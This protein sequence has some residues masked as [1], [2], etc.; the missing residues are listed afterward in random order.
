MRVV[1]TARFGAGLLGLILTSAVWAQSTAALEGTV[2][3]SSGA[4]VPAAKI[5]VRN[6]ATG[7]ERAALS[8]SAGVYLAPS[9]PVGTYSVSVTAPGMQKVVANNILLEIGRTVQQSFTLRAASSSETV[10]VAAAAPLVTSETVDVGAVIDQKTVQDI[11]L[12]GR[13][14]LDMGFLVP[15]SVT[16]PQNAGL[17]A[18]L[19]GQGFFGFNS[20][21]SRDDTINFMMNGIN[22]NDPSNNQITFQP[23]IAT[24]QEFKV[25]NMTFSAEYGR[26]SG[27]IVNIATR[28]GT[29]LW[30]GELYEYLRNNAM[31]ARNFGNPKGLQA[32][33]PFHRNQFGG[34]GGGPIKKDKTFFYLSYEG[35]RHV[36]GI[37]LSSTV[38]TDAQRAQ[39]A[40]TGDAVVRKLLTLI[41]TA[42]SP[43]GVFISSAT[44]PVSLDQGTVNFSHSFSDSSRLNVYYAYQSDL[45]NEP[46]STLNNTLPGYGDT[47][48]GHRQLL[49]VNHT[50]VLS[51][52][53]VNEARLGFNRIHITFIPI[54]NLSSTDYGI[55]NGTS[56]MPQINIA[57]GTLEFGG[58]SGEPNGRGDYTAVL[59][60]SLNWVRGKHSIK[61]GGEYRRINN[62]NFTYSPGSFTF[63]SITAFINDQATGF[64]AN[65]S[66]QA[67]RIYGNA[68]GFFVQDSYRVLPNFMV[69]AG[70]RY[71]WNST[72]TEG[73][74]R[75][76]V[77]DPTTR[78]LV[79]STQPFNQS[80]SFEPRLGF[81]WDVFGHGKAVI[82]AA[83]ALQTDQ[84]KTSLV[85][86]LASNPPNAFPV[87]F[88]PTPAT[89][90]VTFSN[91]FALA[92]GSVSPT[93]IA[94]NYKDAYVQ[95]WNFNIQQ[96]LSSSLSVMAG[97]FAN[98][99]TDLNIG[100][101]Y[102]Q[103]IG[104]ARPY[105]ALSANSPI[106]PGRPLANITVYE[107]GGNSTYNALWLT[108]T[109]RMAKGLQFN[110][111][112]TWSK[113]ID[114][115]S[116]N[117]QGVAVQ[118]SYNL[119]GDR[120]LSDYDA[121][122]RLVL[123]GLYNL[124]FHGN[125]LVEGWEL[126]TILTLQ[127]GNPVTF[128]TSNRSLTGSGNIR[129]SATGPVQV[130]YSPAPNGNATYVAYVQNPT[131]FYDQGNA[132]GNVGRNVVIGPGFSNLD[133]AI[134]KN[135]K[136]REHLTWQ[137]RGDAFDI[138]NHAN[139][140]QPGGT[141]GTS[142]FGQITNTRW[143]TGDSGSSRQLQVAMKLTF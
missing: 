89:P 66:N 98:K 88:S 45:R 20:A 35:L 134:I 111:S 31:D 110:T 34:D 49:T 122:H 46:P 81:S 22:L 69:V 100:R 23:T 77:F 106:F 4:V 9:L 8:D 13:H 90:F 102:N 38:L 87:S 36:Q 107:S 42:N 15:G 79:P 12:N 68:L 125:R 19:R 136:L 80:L 131:V 85:A 94:R 7:E 67:S 16:P 113:S 83:Y 133:F 141:V 55:N 2:T 97:Y 127:S 1:F 140:G 99:G 129:A 44:A 121:R 82:R 29:N 30:H 64:A 33:S 96:Q 132:F 70:L 37:P 48:T 72:P 114:Y 78:S 54:A 73:A 27:A 104:G 126:A 91:A 124:P 84:P 17:A 108:A 43:G 109:K 60:D 76:V 14:F 50:E 57:G 137:V 115:N 39:A 138:L 135:V 116:R 6:L 10:E 26:N 3:D 40:A 53:L 65:P 128:F 25:D 18:P 95:S 41:P 47:R 71:D 75:F 118:D 92:G 21:G 5:V 11:P 58:V 63:S 123:N 117:V 101:N 119:R 105:P 130:G 61:L 28:S 103:F 142:T 143:P 56:L 86:G 93:S 52:S 62:N 32:Q 139:L 120:G 51:N 112:Y 24:V 59:S 74:G